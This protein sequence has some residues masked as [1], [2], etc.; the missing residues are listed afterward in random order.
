MS[1]ASLV[2]SVGQS[3]L[4]KLSKRKSIEPWKRPGFTMVD[5]FRSLCKDQG[6][7]TPLDVKFRANIEG[8]LVDMY[9]R[10]GNKYPAIN[11]RA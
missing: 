4:L 10:P 2:A 3:S 9:Q 5:L 6:F 8:P 7:E 11:T 1:V